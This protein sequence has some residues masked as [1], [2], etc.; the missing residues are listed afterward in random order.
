MKAGAPVRTIG[1]WIVTASSVG[2]PSVEDAVKAAGEGASL[3]PEPGLP[4]AVQGWSKLV[5]DWVGHQIR[6][7]WV[8]GVAVRISIRMFRS[9][10]GQVGLPTAPLG[11]AGAPMPREASDR[12]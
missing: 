9:R 11:D 7:R 10:E 4:I 12:G 3:T 6:S 8:L 2:D 5:S 1:S